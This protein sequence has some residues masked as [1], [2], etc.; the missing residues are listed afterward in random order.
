MLEL[1]AKW[2]IPDRENVTEPAVRLRYGVLCGATGI[3]LN[4]LLF[5]GK[6]LGGMLSRSIAVTA[7]AFNNLSDAFSSVVTLAGFRIAN[8]KADREHP[9]GHGRF[10]YIA[11]LMVSMLIL[12]M[13]VEL[14]KS[15]VQK[16]VRPEAVGFSWL[17]AGILAASMLVKVYMFLYNRRI[18]RRIDSSAMRAA[19][20]DSLSD[21][22]ATGAVLLSTLIGKWTGLAIDG[23]TGLAVAL[24][25]L[26][27]GVRAVLDTIG[28][29]LGQP[30][31][32]AFTGRIES[33]VLS[34]PEVV[35]VHDLVVH[36][37]GPGRVAVSLHAEVPADGDILMLHDAVDNL[38]RR[39]RDELGCMAVIHMDPV[40]AG[41]ENVDRYK[42]IVTAIA[43]EI[44]PRL[45]IH[46]FRYVPG[47]THT[48]LVFD[49]V[50]PY[51][52]SVPDEEIKRQICSRVR[53]LDGAYYAVVEID[54]AVD[55][56]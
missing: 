26:Y 52:L 36:D 13:G 41:D 4:V 27:A 3:A 2:C 46:D 8:R 42:A 28:P 7:D 53:A 37:Y 34:A 9:F 23:W 35:G 11:G 1:L 40:V 47:T 10:E 19:A 15:S 20:L 24:F 55:A 44:D 38:E 17:T 12:L 22:A 25:I 30:P 18:G 39:L 48:N 29:L 14:I 16:I 49:V 50:A 45:T 54:K 51:G 32:K 21:V 5:I 31:T 33:L 56:E 43:Q 6:L